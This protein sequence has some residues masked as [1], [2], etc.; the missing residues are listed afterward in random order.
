MCTFRRLH[1]PPSAKIGR[2]LLRCAKKTLA[3]MVDVPLPELENELFP[4]TNKKQETRRGVDGF[5]GFTMLH[6]FDLQ[7]FHLPFCQ[8]FLVEIYLTEESLTR[9]NPSA[10]SSFEVWRERIQIYQGNIL[11]RQ[12][13]YVFFQSIYSQVFPPRVMVQ[14]NLGETESTQEGK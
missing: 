13:F 9:I 8:A 4:N 11:I 3:S 5:D 1:R 6:I 10:G 14:E 12:N 7:T 2:L